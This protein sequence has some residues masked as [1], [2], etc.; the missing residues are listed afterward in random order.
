MLGECRKVRAENGKDT[1]DAKVGGM[2]N[3]QKTAIKQML[4]TALCSGVEW[5]TEFWV[6]VGS[7]RLCQPPLTPPSPTSHCVPNVRPLWEVSRL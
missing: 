6:S 7:S 1:K 5:A 4:S 2:K 3:L